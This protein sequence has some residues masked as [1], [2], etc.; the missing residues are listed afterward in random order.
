MIRALILSFP[1]HSSFVFFI[2]KY[3]EILLILTKIH[4]IS[5]DIKFFEF[6]EICFCMI[7]YRVK[8]YACSNKRKRNVLIIT[9][10]HWIRFL[11]DFLSFEF[12][13]LLS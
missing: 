8:S 11:F 3:G 2:S 6:V 10:S 12:R 5:F 7:L 1:A 4:E 13:S 9:N